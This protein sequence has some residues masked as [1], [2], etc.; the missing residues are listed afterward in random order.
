MVWLLMRCI[1]CHFPAVNEQKPGSKTYCSCR[2]MGDR[3]PAKFNQ[4]SYYLTSCCLIIHAILK[5]AV[6][7]AISTEK[8]Q[9]ANSI[10][11]RCQSA[12]RLKRLWTAGKQWKFVSQ[13]TRFWQVRRTR[14]T[15]RMRVATSVTELDVQLN[16]LHWKIKPNLMRRKNIKA[17][18]NAARTEDVLSFQA[19][20]NDRIFTR[21]SGV[22]LPDKHAEILIN[23]NSSFIYT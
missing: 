11:K 12:L 5:S 10:I 15:G 6:W 21:F 8:V 20:K 16:P 22:S 2:V 4:N 17:A 19:L 3:P 14:V 23:G 13:A 9:H 18:Y 7:K 1:L